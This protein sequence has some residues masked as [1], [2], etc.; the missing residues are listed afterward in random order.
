MADAKEAPRGGTC[1]RGKGKK[2]KFGG[3][4]LGLKL[5]EK[6]DVL[7]KKTSRKTRWHG[8]I[9]K[10]VLKEAAKGNKYLLKANFFN[11]RENVGGGEPTPKML[12]I[13]RREEKKNGTKARGENGGTTQQGNN[14]NRRPGEPENRHGTDRSVKLKKDQKCKVLGIEKAKRIKTD[15]P[16][17]GKKK[18]KRVRP[19]D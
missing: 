8:A 6:T 16:K 19:A 3:G 10:F 9:T 1:Q 17:R 15:R 7:K 18:K 11:R 5:K 4:S 12:D 2:D 13:S 14:R